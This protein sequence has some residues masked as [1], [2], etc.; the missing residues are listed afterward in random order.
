MSS[1][2]FYGMSAEVRKVEGVDCKDK[3]WFYTIPACNPAR[4]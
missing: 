4:N 1:G 2:T 3:K